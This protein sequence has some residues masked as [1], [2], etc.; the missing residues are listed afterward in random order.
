[1]STKEKAM[2][3]WQ[4]EG[5]FETRLLTNS[6]EHQLFITVVNSTPCSSVIK[7]SYKIINTLA[8]VS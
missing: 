6:E 5:T 7:T 3:Q 8:P 4:I 1:M 2:G